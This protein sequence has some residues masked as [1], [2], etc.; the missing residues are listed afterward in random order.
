MVNTWVEEREERTATANTATNTFESKLDLQRER[1]RQMV[2]L[3]HVL[4]Y[5]AAAAALLF[6]TLSLGRVTEKFPARRR[7]LIA[8][9]H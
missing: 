3:L 8:R 7:V 2:L 9:M 5:V 6:V 1:Q 4:G